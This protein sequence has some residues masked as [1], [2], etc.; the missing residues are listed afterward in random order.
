VVLPV[1]LCAKAQDLLGSK[2]GGTRKVVLIL[3]DFTFLNK[4]N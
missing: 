3:L 2:C 4:N 1:V